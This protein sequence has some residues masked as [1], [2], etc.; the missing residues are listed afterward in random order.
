MRVP[1]H[2]AEHQGVSALPSTALAAGLPLASVVALALAPMARFS[3]SGAGAAAA[4]AGSAAA[5][6]AP[7]R[8]AAAPPR[9]RRRFH[10]TVMSAPPVEVS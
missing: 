5:A 7:A 6:S 3:S 9:H 4:G 8:S 1:V 2:S 10:R